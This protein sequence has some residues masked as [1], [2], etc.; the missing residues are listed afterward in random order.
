MYMY[1]EK[2]TTTDKTENMELVALKIAQ[3]LILQDYCTVTAS[4][5]FQR[6]IIHVVT[7]NSILY[8]TKQIVLTT[9]QDP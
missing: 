1:S 7:A 3:P 8:N 5:Y 4:F 6:S 9:Q 2:K